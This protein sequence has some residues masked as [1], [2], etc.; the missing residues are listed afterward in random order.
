MFSKET[1][2]WLDRCNNPGLCSA[3]AGT[4]GADSR[5]ISANAPPAVQAELNSFYAVQRQREEEQ[6]RASTQMRGANEKFYA[7]MNAMNPS[8]NK[9][10]YSFTTSSITS[11]FDS[12]S[13][14]LTGLGSSALFSPT[15]SSITGHSSLNLPNSSLGGPDFGNSKW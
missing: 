6:Q 5:Y 4:W 9:P 1:Q 14:S 11:V 12:P 2:N 8:I 3:I 15:S 7:S 13:S 10:S